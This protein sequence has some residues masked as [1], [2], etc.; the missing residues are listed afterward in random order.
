MKR[1]S[2][3]PLHVA[4]LSHIEGHA[5]V[6][7]W[8][9][10]WLFCLAQLPMKSDEQARQW[11]RE[12]F[13][14]RQIVLVWDVLDPAVQAATEE[15]W[16]RWLRKGEPM[17]EDEVPSRKRRARLYAENHPGHVAML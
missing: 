3:P 1:Y 2:D 17:K 8:D 6:E 15:G 13:E 12:A 11:A 4:R 14:Q 10:L 9:S 16:Q 7:L 5:V